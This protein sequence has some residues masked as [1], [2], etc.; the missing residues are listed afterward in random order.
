MYKFINI[1]MAVFLLSPATGISGGAMNFDGV[2]DCVNL[3]NVISAPEE[4]SISAWVRPDT[5]TEEFNIL[6]KGIGASGDRE[7]GLS[8]IYGKV[9]GLVADESAND[10]DVIGG[11]TTI[12]AGEWSHASMT[13]NGTVMKVYLNGIEDGS[14]ITSVNSGDIESLTADLEIGKDVS[15]DYAD[16]SIGEVL[17]YNRALPAAEI[18]AIYASKNAWY[19][20]TGL[21]SRWSMEKNGINTGQSHPNGSTVKDSAGSNDG[22]INDGAD[23]SMTLTSSPTRKKRGRR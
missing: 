6:I 3:G 22:T 18:K 7:Y 10:V 2:E 19:P 4:L 15:P 1:L 21:V 8:I 17:I 12:P 14:V 20:K 5:I 23:G 11:N 9:R 13:W 16:G